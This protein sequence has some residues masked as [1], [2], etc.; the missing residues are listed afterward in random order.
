MSGI[1]NPSKLQSA[2][3]QA[4]SPLRYSIRIMAVA[5]SG[6]TTTI[7]AALNLLPAG[8]RIAFVAFN[9]AIVTELKQRVPGRVYVMTLHSMGFTALRRLSS[10]E[11]EVDEKKCVKL[12]AAIQA[13][14]SDSD[15]ER[16]AELSN[17]TLKLVDLAKAHGIV[18]G[19]GH[20][21][22]PGLLSDNRHDWDY[23]IDHFD[24]DVNDRETFVISITRQVLAQSIADNRVIDYNDMLYMPVIHKAPFWKY[25]VIFVDE[26]QDLSVIQHVMLQRALKPR[27]LVVAVGD[28]H[29]AIYGFRGADV[30]SMDKMAVMFGMQDFPLSISY[31]CFP[32]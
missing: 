5:G 28:P 24:V 19:V 14:F 4:V 20:A 31:R 23:L 30:D 12:L 7:V 9:K 2:I 29:Q 15:F 11:L 10:V 25:D 26:S 6:K 32:L 18:P 8:M 17:A 1:D 3:F 16:F 13:S 27:G 22:A 21:V